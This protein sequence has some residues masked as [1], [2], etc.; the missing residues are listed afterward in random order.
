MHDDVDK[1]LV[2]GIFHHELDRLRAEGR[3]LFVEFVLCHA[4]VLVG[5][6]V[7]LVDATEGDAHDRQG[8]RDEQAAH[9]DGQPAGMA[10]GPAWKL[11][12]PG[13]LNGA[14]RSRGTAHGPGIDL[15]AEHAKNGRQHGDGKERG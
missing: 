7:G 2:R 9:G 13:V 8:E 11:I 5:W 12:P 1:L 4:G 14:S 3:E 10:H 15:G 6:Q